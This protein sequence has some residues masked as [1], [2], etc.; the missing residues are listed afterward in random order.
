[1]YEVLLAVAV[2]KFYEDADAP[3]QRKLDRCFEQLKSD[4]PLHQGLSLEL[5]PL[6]GAE[7][8]PEPKPGVSSP[9]T[10]GVD[11]CSLRFD[12]CVSM[13]IVPGGGAIRSASA[14]N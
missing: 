7:A 11:P 14:P 2:R 8:E 6:Q 3:L 13:L 10:S 1:M 5:R 12:A 9:G 4:A